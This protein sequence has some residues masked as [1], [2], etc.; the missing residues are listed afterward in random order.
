M[1]WENLPEKDRIR[2]QDRILKDDEL[3]A[4]DAEFYNLLDTVD[5]AVKEK[6][7]DAYIEY[8]VRAMQLAYIQGIEDCKNE[9][10]VSEENADERKEELT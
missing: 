2:L 10:P 8:G 4:I 3:K 5:D 1:I 7:E 6:L 9:M